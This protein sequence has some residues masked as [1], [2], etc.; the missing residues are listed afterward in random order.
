MQHQKKFF[1]VLNNVFDMNM[2]IY[3]PSITFIYLRS[4]FFVEAKYYKMFTLLGQSIGSMILGL[5]ALLRF[6]T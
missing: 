1:I 4:R 5:E 2:Q 3:K 6:C